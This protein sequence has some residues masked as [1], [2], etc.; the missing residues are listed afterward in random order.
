MFKMTGYHI[1]I[2]QL[3][4]WQVIILQHVELKYEKTFVL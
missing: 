4:Y 3:I 1:P 2:Y